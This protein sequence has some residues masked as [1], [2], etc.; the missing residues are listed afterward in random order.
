MPYPGIA[1]V[2]REAATARDD[3]DAHATLRILLTAHY[4][5]TEM[6]AEQAQQLRALLLRGNGRDRNLSRGGLALNVLWH[7]ARRE[8]PHEA[9]DHQIA[10]NEEIRR[11]AAVLVAYRDELAA[12]REHMATL[13]N[14]LV[15]GITAEPGM[16]PFKAA[17]AILDTGTFALDHSGNI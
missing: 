1:D 5:L 13:V 16:G 3:A 12:N 10:R 9:T 14:D 17:K 4:E 6:A 2:D 11:L 8:P 7:L 15:P